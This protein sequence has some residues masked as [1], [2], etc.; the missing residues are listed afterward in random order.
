MSAQVQ[1]LPQS[2]IERKIKTMKVAAQVVQ[3]MLLRK[4][5]KLINNK[6]ASF[7]IRN[8]RWIPHL[9]AIPKWGQ[10]RSGKVRRQASPRHA[11]LSPV[12]PNTHP[13]ISQ[14]LPPVTGFKLIKKKHWT[15]CLCYP[16]KLFTE[17]QFSLREMEWQQKRSVFPREMKIHVSSVL[18][19][20]LPCQR[21][22]GA[23]IFFS[24]MIYFQSNNYIVRLLGTLSYKH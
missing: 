4:I 19:S 12:P 17:K 22:T 15:P 18:F 21:D 24:Y 2:K 13:P 5:K 3:T 20:S 16:Q 14:G 1:T 10:E 8:L 6:V 9:A 11:H 23:Q 7:Q